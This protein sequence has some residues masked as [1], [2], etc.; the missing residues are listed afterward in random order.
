MEEKIQTMDTSS[1]PADTQETSEYQ[2]AKRV[3][4][5]SNCSFSRPKKYIKS[6]AKYQK[7]STTSNFTSDNLF[8]I[9]QA[10][11]DAQT[12]TT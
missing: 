2:T 8:S 1:P 7:R 11:Y 9:L 10:E 12:P 6:H 4:T 3:N 5:T